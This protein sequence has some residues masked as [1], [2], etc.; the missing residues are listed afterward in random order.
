LKAQIQACGRIPISSVGLRKPEGIISEE[1]EREK[2][3]ERLPRERDYATL[4]TIRLYALI[5]G[6]NWR[7]AERR[8]DPTRYFIIIVVFTVRR[9]A[10]RVGG[11]RLI[12]F[13]FQNRRMNED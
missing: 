3:R 5:A 9:R 1:E 4:P 12:A 7:A 13:A 10:R 8:E 11:P 2:E 6:R